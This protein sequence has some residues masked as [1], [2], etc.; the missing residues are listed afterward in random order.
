M[1]RQ[2]G[3]RASDLGWW[4]QEKGILRGTVYSFLENTSYRFSG[5]GL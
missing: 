3:K 4:E 2:G 1:K 5:Q